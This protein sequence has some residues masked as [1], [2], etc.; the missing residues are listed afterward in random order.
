[1]S[2]VINGPQGAKSKNQGRTYLY[3]HFE[4]LCS[5]CVTLL[6]LHK[7]GQ[8]RKR[9]R[10]SYHPVFLQ[11][12][13]RPESQERFTP[14]QRRRGWWR[15]QKGSEPWKPFVWIECVGWSFISHVQSCLAL[16]HPA[17]PHVFLCPPA[18]AAVLCGSYLQR[19]NTPRPH[20]RPDDGREGETEVK[21]CVLL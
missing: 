9:V 6:S 2:T 15:C 14:R 5:R 10:V 16:I 1:M 8:K 18:G 21:P 4:F 13:W 12:C 7:K 17:N 19:A 11:A 3:K 20:P